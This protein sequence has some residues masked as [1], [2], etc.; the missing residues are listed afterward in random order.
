MNDQQSTLVAIG[1]AALI[2]F[3]A[4]SGILVEFWRI[5]PMSTFAQNV[6]PIVQQIIVIVIVMAAIIGV[7]ILASIKKVKQKRVLDA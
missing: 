5:S 3:L 2:V 7:A 4:W 1:A 6:S